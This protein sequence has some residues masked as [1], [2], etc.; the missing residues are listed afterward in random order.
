[1]SGVA[2]C[3]CDNSIYR[4]KTIADLAPSVTCDSSV[5]I[6]S[7]SKC[8]LDALGYD[9]SSFHLNE[10]I[11]W[12]SSSYPD[13]INNQRVQSFWVS[14]RAGWIGWTEWT[15]WRWRT[16]AELCGNVV[17]SDSSKVNYTNT[18]HIGIMDTPLITA[19]PINYNFTCSYN[20]T[21]QSSLNFSAS[22]VS[23]T[24]N[25]TAEGAG[26]VPVTMAAYRDPDYSL[27]VL[28]GQTV[29]MGSDLYLGLFTT[30]VDR[31]TFTLRVEKCFVGPSD[32]PN[33]VNKVPLVTGG[34]P[35]NQGLY[36]EVNVNGAALEARIAM[37]SFA[38]QNQPKVFIFCDVRLCDKTGI[39]T[40]CNV[41]RAAGADTSQV[42]IS[43]YVDSAA[44]SC[45]AGIDPPLCSSCSGSCAEEYEYGC[46]C[47]DKVIPCVPTT[48]CAM[49]SYG[50]CPI[51]LFWDPSRSCC[52]DAIPFFPKEL[53]HD[54]W[55]G[56]T[57]ECNST[58][59]QN[60][61]PGDAV[62][63]LT[64]D[65]G[66]MSVSLS[67]CRLAQFGYDYQSL[68]LDNSSDSCNSTYPDVS[69]NTRVLVIQAKPATGWCGNQVTVNASD[70][71][72]SNIVHI[73][74]NSGGAGSRGELKVTFSCVYSLYWDTQL[75]LAL[76]QDNGTLTLSAVYGNDGDL[77]AAIYSNA[78]YTEPLSLGDTF[79]ASAYNTVYI[80]V[81]TNFTDTERF[82]LRVEEVFAAPDND[83][84][85][86]SRVQLIS[87]GVG[88]DRQL[89]TRGIQ[90]GRSAEVKFSV[91]MQQF[92]EQS[93]TYLFFTAR[94][95]DSYTERCSSK[96]LV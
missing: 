45:Y 11:Y 83:P 35:A 13:I 81:I 9:Y 2:T 37:L 18:V 61:T 47:N 20:L 84:T 44:G 80:T 21:M 49:V 28:Y 57:C 34:C 54:V 4:N 48:E 19:N 53:C 58:A 55:G 68:R 39:C 86:T 5:M 3:V 72:Y 71:V 60:A 43:L 90:N 36:T 56:A 52:S 82:R 51:N 41:G 77:S 33:D 25:L 7:V 85:S 50:C 62:V 64:C 95:C 69:N 78:D 15:G 88:S 1:M 24:V 91:Q 96:F 26:T 73:Q 38:F 59:P 46:L 74:N 76:H 75:L 22:A 92:A 10:K 42:G 65:T 40:G 67:M 79:S 87:G 23:S 89:L 31:D 8:L 27:P 14:L 63:S 66:V 94:L 30:F 29:P 93:R 32:D 12:C 17:T 6:V 70:V 16:R